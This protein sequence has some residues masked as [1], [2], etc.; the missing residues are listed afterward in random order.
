M[1]ERSLLKAS[2]TT[3]LAL[4]LFCRKV[5]PK[6]VT[7][8]FWQATRK[9]IAKKVNKRML[10]FLFTKLFLVMLVFLCWLIASPEQS[11]FYRGFLAS[12]CNN[13]GPD[14]YYFVSMY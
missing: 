11:I 12:L 14:C 2:A 6:V 10:L 7:G 4:L 8:C 5:L 1:V 3:T 9:N 13:K